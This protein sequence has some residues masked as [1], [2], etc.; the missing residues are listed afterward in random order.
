MTRI[1]IQ[2]IGPIKDVTVEL[3][4]VN[5]FMGPQ[6][7]GKSTIAKIISYCSWYEK[8]SILHA[9]RRP[10][11]WK[12]L[13]TFHNL[14]D[15]YFSQESRIAYIS[16]FCSFDMKWGNKKSEGIYHKK[17]QIFRNRKISYIP[18]ERN[19]VT[20]P[21]LGK[22][23][24]SRDNTLSFLYDW[25]LAK[26]E[27]SETNVFDLPIR[28]LGNVSFFY[29]KKIESD[30][31]RVQN[32]KILGLNHTSSGLR[33]CIPLL[34]VFDYMLNAIYKN[35]RT[36]TPFE[37][38]NLYEK[39]IAIQKLDVDFGKQKAPEKSLH[40]MFNKP[41]EDMDE[42]QSFKDKWEGLI[43]FYDEYFYSLAI[44][45]E[46]ELNLFPKTQRDLVYY[47]LSTLAQ[48]KR[49]HQLV[50]TTHSPFILFAVNN[51]MMGGLVKNNIP[52]SESK[53][54]PSQKSWIN[55]LDVAIYE[56]DNGS[57]RCIQDKDGIIEDN[58]LNQA[59]Q[60]STDEYL[61]MLN[62]YEDE[63]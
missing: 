7:S 35:P 41:R 51:C 12:E 57:I 61:A 34:V 39:L 38:V 33:S 50:L 46:P 10:D 40:E 17:K 29:D 60:E 49:D 53:Q 30:K 56:I 20:I 37:F 13:I 5:V 23:N 31:V 2:N 19:F 48:S 59:Y 58:Y 62:Y 15:T 16:D 11:F 54:L 21:S 8:N 47:M 28:S 44:I 3:K 36:Q 14:E 24:E 43:G 45:E 52:K 32:D 63:E 18:A 4:K 42:L 9:S 55:P 26:K 22:Y 25:F 6:S 27:F 1:T